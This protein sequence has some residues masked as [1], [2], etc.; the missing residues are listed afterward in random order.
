LGAA[1]R[2]DRA[3]ALPHAPLALKPLKMEGLRTI[4]WRTGTSSHHE[5]SCRIENSRDEVYCV[6][7]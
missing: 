6:A 1:R 2:L 7:L 3:R 4:C 5:I